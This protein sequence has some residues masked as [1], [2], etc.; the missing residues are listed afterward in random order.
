[1]SWFPLFIDL[2][3]KSVVMYGAGQIAA[4]RLRGLLRFGAQVTV[5]AP[6]LSDEVR[7][8]AQEYTQSMTLRV[9]RYQPGRIP[10]AALVLSATDDPQ[11]DREIAAECRAKGIPVNIASDQSLCDFYFPA[12]VEQDGIVAGISSGGADHKRVRRVSAAIRAVL[13]EEEEADG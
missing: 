2:K 7:A 6:D 4:R 3:G 10:D 13:A 12:L 5:I 1:M 9:Q 8:L 11:T